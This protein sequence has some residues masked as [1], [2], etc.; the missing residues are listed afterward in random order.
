MTVSVAEGIIM[1]YTCLVNVFLL[2]EN[3]TI[4]MVVGGVPDS[5][6]SNVELIDMSGQNRDC[7]VPNDY[8]LRIKGPVGAF[9][10]DK[11]IVCG[12]F[13]L[14]NSRVAVPDCF[15][16]NAVNATW[17]RTTSMIHKRRAAASTI[18]QNKWLITGGIEYL[19]TA[20]SSTEMLHINNR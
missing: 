14:Y 18:F 16:Y 8:P 3:L 5:A 7:K 19:T 2:V 15:E 10:N 1:D 20:L 17:S 13:P 9:V 4:L 12:G 11:A 6:S